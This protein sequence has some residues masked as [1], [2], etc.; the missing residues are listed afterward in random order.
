MSLLVAPYLHHWTSKLWKVWKKMEPYALA[1]KATRIILLLDDTK[2]KDA[3]KQVKGVALLVT[4]EV[5][6]KG[7]GC[8]LLLSLLLFCSVASFPSI[9]FSYGET[10]AL[11]SIL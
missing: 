3:V 8:I 7:Y 2:A 1:C 11:T 9:L 10:T 5:S 4:R 6:C